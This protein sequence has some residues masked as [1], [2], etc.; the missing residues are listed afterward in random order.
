MPRPLRSPDLEWQGKEHGLV[1][2]TPLLDIRAVAGHQ[3][4]YRGLDERVGHARPGRDDDGGSTLEP[5]RAQ[6]VRSFDEESRD[7]LVR[8]HLDQAPGVGAVAAADDQDHIRLDSQVANGHLPILRRVADI[9]PRRADDT[10]KPTLQRLDDEP[11]MPF[12]WPR[13][14]VFPLITTSYR[15]SLCI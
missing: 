10:R 3:Y 14:P 6:R 9:L 15:P 5:F 4:R 12:R 7:A 11:R 8:G 2:H 1:G 13:S